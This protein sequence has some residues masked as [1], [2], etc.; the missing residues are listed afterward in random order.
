[1]DNG[2]IDMWINILIWLVVVVLAI[3]VEVN[4]FQ[5]VSVWFAISGFVAMILA[6]F[7]CLIEIQL[8]VFILLSAILII[9]SRFIVKKLHAGKSDNSTV[10]SL[11]G[12]EVVVTKEIKTG[13]VGEIKAKYEKYSALAPDSNYNIPVGTLVIIKEIRGNKVIVEVK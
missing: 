1:M 3:V 2:N 4:T 9:I 7:E 12:E 8:I 13:E 10:E 6:A 5:I 11:L